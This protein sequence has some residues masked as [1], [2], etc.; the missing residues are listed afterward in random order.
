MI[1][2]PRRGAL[3]EVVT[4]TAGYG[5]D[6]GTGA[7]AGRTVGALVQ[8]TREEVLER[9]A[10]KR[11]RASGD[12]TDDSD[13]DI[14]GGSDASPERRPAKVTGGAGPH[15]G[16]RAV[17][18]VPTRIITQARD[19]GHLM[20]FRELGQLRGR[21][22]EQLK[23]LVQDTQARGFLAQ[24][25]LALPPTWYAEFVNAMAAFHEHRM[26]L[27]EL[28]RVTAIVLQH[29]PALLADFRQFL[30]PGLSI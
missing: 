14:L 28:L 6:G 27:Y 4:G 21:P 10:R 24:A 23:T 8:P 18:Q 16:M 2:R 29:H 5:D 30:P 7:G 25:E 26:P 20:P 22:A 15:L 9:R 19:Q 1:F 17:R 3:T 11:K 13:V 12:E